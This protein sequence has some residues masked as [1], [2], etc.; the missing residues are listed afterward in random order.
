MYL[1][2]PTQ[3]SRG[4]LMLLH[5]AEQCGLKRSDLLDKCGLTNDIFADPDSRIPT[6]SM[7]RLWR[8]VIDEIDDPILGLNTGKIPG[9]V[10]FGLVGYAMRYSNNLQDALHRLARYQ[11]ILSEAVRFTLSEREDACV[12]TWVSHP[13]LL[14]LR[15]PTESAMMLLMRAA[16]ELTGEDLR[17]QKV[18]LPTPPPEDTAPYK[19]A[20]RCEVAFA[21]DT[22][23]ITW[24][25]RQME[26]PT[27][28]A[29]PALVGYLDQLAS[30]AV[31]PIDAGKDST[32]TA[33]R[34]ALWAMLP[35]GRPNIWRT[36]QELGVSVRTLQR[37]L[38]E[39]GS[40]FSTVLDT[41]RR[42]VTRE[43]LAEGKQPVAD[44]S[45]LLGYSEP[46]A[47]HRAYRRWTDNAG[48]GGAR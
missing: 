8:A 29:D 30:I 45:F 23:A 48:S 27:V 39:E 36:A 33:V 20:F 42:D 26:L 34:R 46:S 41:L 15:H 21:C 44:I 24:T 5:Y 1:K 19:K 40:S 10:D 35:G 25:S 14:A 9:L 12:L 17:P 3:L 32:T 2:D 47:F 16:S 31:G 38:G 37:R 11:R 28:T 7:V 43:L 4:P 22:A 13:A 6:R 18:E